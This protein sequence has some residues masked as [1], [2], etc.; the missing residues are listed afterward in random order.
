MWALK[1]SPETELSLKRPA[2]EFGGTL[3]IWLSNNRA[4]PVQAFVCLDGESIMFADLPGRG[5]LARF[6]SREYGAKSAFTPTPGRHEVKVLVAGFGEVGR[7]EFDQDVGKTNYVSIYINTDI[8]KLG[9]RIILKTS[10]A[11]AM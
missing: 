6:R 7:Q 8:K 3:R 1:P 11:G 2:P 4:N 5:L 10:P 9:C